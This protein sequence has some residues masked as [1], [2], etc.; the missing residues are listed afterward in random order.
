M[1]GPAEIATV[2]ASETLYTPDDCAKQLR[3]SRSM[4][5]T[6]IKRG[7]LRA[8]YVGRLPRVTESALRDYL[9]AAAAPRG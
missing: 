5:Y 7:K 2:A 9:A 6:E 8:L 4:I 3:V 1:T